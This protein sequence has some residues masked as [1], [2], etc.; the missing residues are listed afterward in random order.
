MK[1]DVLAIGVHPDDVEL[2][3]AGTLITQVQQGKT[4]AILDLTAGELGTRGSAELRLKEAAAAAEIMGVSERINL[5]MQDGFFE[6]TKKD[7]MRIIE[8]IR[9][10][11]PEIVLTN[12]VEDR[13]PDHGRAAK[14]T[15]DACF[16]A[17]L[18]KIETTRDGEVQEAWRPKKVYHYIQDYN[19]EAAFVVDITTGIDTK[20]EAILAYGSQFY[21]PNSS[22]PKTP[23]SGADFLAFVK[24]KN[25]VYGRHAGFEFG[26]G[27]TSA[28]VPGVKDLFDL[29]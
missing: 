8:V 29:S 22:E 12:A 15:A 2:S 9:Y 28:T 27:F 23:I 3:C 25:R 10:F 13:H 7:L 14:L 21:D 26:E 19:L 5:G 16:Y 11:K 1:V 4:T 24:S 6:Y 17:G 20:L 18:R